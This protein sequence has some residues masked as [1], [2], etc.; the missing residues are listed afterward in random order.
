MRLQSDPVDFAHRAIAKRYWTVTAVRANV[1]AGFP[2]LAY[3]TGL[4]SLGHSELIIYGLDPGVAGSILNTVGHRISRGGGTLTAGER[5][6][7]FIDDDLDLMVIEALTTTDL[8]VA[9]A[10]YGEVSAWQ[11]VWPDATGEYPWSTHYGMA[12]TAQPLAGLPAA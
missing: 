4:T 11:L 5:L 12:R 6:S 1:A 9:R 3:T 8:R 10:V 2:S 7:G